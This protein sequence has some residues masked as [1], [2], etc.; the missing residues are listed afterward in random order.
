MLKTLKDLVHIN[1]LTGKKFMYGYIE[2]TK[3]REL[4]EKWKKH[5]EDLDR[6]EP[7]CIG[8]IRVDYRTVIGF[9]DHFFNLETDEET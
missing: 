3:I 4:G 2:D 8:G 1:E 7:F 9:I 6:E 5:F